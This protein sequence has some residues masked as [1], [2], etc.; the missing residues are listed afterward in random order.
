MSTATHET[1]NI[2]LSRIGN[3]EGL[4]EALSD[5]G[6]V[7]SVV[8]AGNTLVISYDAVE[9]QW[10]EIEQLIKSNQFEIKG[11]LFSKW[12]RSWFQYSDVN[13]RDNF[14]HKPHCCNKPPK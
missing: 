1:R 8:L 2:K 6:G 13:A 7:V 12:R 10:K 3:S 4:S 11:G 9:I 5:I 14:N